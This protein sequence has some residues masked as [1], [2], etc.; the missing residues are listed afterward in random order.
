MLRPAFSIVAGQSPKPTGVDFF[1]A[2][3]NERSDLE[4]LFPKHTT[5]AFLGGVA[6]NFNG[7]MAYFP[8]Q[9]NSAYT[10]IVGGK[11]TRE[12]V[13]K[14]PRVDNIPDDGFKAPSIKD[15]VKQIELE[16]NILRHL[17][18]RGLPVPELTCKGKE[19][20]FIGMTRMKG[21]EL[22]SVVLDRMDKR[23][24]RQFAKDIAGFISGFEKAISAQD[25]KLLGF[26]E[27]ALT[28][29]EMKPED[30]Q[31]ALADPA[32]VEVLGNDADFCRDMQAVFEKRYEKEY[33]DVPQVASH[34]D[35]HFDNILYDPETKRLS[36]VIDFGGVGFC[37]PELNFGVFSQKCKDD[38]TSM[39]CEEY[40]KESGNKVTLRDIRVSECARYVVILSQMLESRNEKE[41][42]YAKQQISEL[43]K[44]LAPEPEK[45]TP[46]PLKAAPFNR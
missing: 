18:G 26:R 23:E 22:N 35:L 31:R 42:Q 44:S 38:I 27:D 25:A 34:G 45:N 2:I 17:K 19:T 24:K 30:S 1:R 8:E 20:V 28:A 33:R 36:G 37:R 5:S 41:A 3:L 16:G 7:A 9:G 29:M 4:A 15:R 14:A 11:V 21:V 12:E 6:P 13:F 39:I 46:A 40:S 43:R 10:V 32:V